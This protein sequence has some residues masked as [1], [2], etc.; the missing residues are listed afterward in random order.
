MGKI[1]PVDFAQPAFLDQAKHKTIEFASNVEPGFGIVSSCKNFLYSLFCDYPIFIQPEN[2]EP[3]VVSKS[4]MPIWSVPLFF[5]P[6][7]P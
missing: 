1:E 5:K 4:I 7:E 3:W 2:P 6:L